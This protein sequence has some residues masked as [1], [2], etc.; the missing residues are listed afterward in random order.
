MRRVLILFGAL[1]AVSV[2]AFSE[3]PVFGPRDPGAARQNL[4]NVDAATGRSALGLGTMATEASTDYVATGTFTGH[5]DATGAAVHGLGT[6]AI[7]SADSVAITGG[8][9]TLTTA[10]ISGFTKLGDD[11]TP[12]KMKIFT[13]TTAATEGG[14]AS[15]THG[16]T[17]AKIVGAQL[18]VTYA[19]NAG[20]TG[21]HT[22]NSELQV[23]VFFDSTRV[24]VQNHATNSG[25]AV[26]KPW[27]ALIWYKE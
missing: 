16:L 6:M 13:G 8:V 20:V 25:S 24:Y 9:A 1:F 11:A 10:E 27:T 26:N 2:A 4:S 15:A 14:T 18:L 3:Q 7:Q 12:I 21:A 17:S 23:D 19:A 5:T 22:A